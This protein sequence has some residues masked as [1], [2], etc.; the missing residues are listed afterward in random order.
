M[1]H[2]NDNDS[3]QDMGEVLLSD[4]Q[5]SEDGDRV[6]PSAQ[7][8]T[9]RENELQALENLLAVIGDEEAFSA[10]T[11]AELRVR[12]GR[13]HNHFEKF[14]RADAEYRAGHL[15]ITN[16][17]YLDVEERYMHAVSKV[18]T[19]LDAE[20][21][22]ERTLSSLDSEPRL[23]TI[24][25]VE[26]PH[27]PQLGTFDG[28]PA[29]WPAFR[30][31]FLSDVDSRNYEPVV[32]LRY[33]QQACVGKAAMTLGPW[34][35][36]GDNYKPAWDMLVRAY[37]DN[38]H[39]IHGILGQM[40]SVP[41]QNEETHASLRLLLDSANGGARQLETLTT[42]DTL[43]D[44]VWIHYIKQRMPK[45]TLDS[46][47]Q[48]RS[49]HGTALLP[50]FAE[51]KDFLDIKS[52]GR[53]EFEGSDLLGPRKQGGQ[54]R[55]NGNYGRSERK[56][57]SDRPRYR[58]SNRFQPRNR[59]EP[60][61]SFERPNTS[62]PFRSRSDNNNPSS[63]V[64]NE[65]RAQDKNGACIMP[66]CTEKHP[67]YMCTKFRNSPLEERKAIVV[68][69]QYCYN[70]INK[71]HRARDCPRDGCYSCPDA[72]SKHNFRLCEKLLQNH[73]ANASGTQ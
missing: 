10:M 21:A 27:T 19:R 46:W 45:T 56:T 13:V 22:Q 5:G 37:D 40:Y 49:R 11:T 62:N 35:P 24:I 66:G 72:K 48:Y 73:G 65:S 54:D 69:H 4:E 14:E 25:K 71:G 1:D 59:F 39:V 57:N 52:K 26:A 51:L 3:V 31:L 63:E 60:Y 20:E 33:L 8:Y 30:D 43:V 61:R 55:P 36:T 32:K 12:L 34:R 53:R 15:A 50:T 9:Y 42:S 29:N 67:L 41:K 7:L 28:N 38:Y 17:L 18:Q 16:A 70:C 68:K 6:P 64:K 23:P 58:D 44:Q 47:E 2:E